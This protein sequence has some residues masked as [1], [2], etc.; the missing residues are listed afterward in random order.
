MNWY[1]VNGGQQA[2]PVDD[3]QLEGL[4]RA[5]QVRAETLV[6]HEGMANW[7]P[8]GQVRPAPQT[9]VGAPPIPAAATVPPATG[10]GEVVCAE[11]GRIFPVD[12]TIQYGT[13]RVCAGCKPVF[14]QKLTEGATVE[15]VLGAFRYG[16]FWIRVAA[17]LLDGLIMGVIIGIP[18]GIWLFA[19]GAL[20]DPRSFSDPGNA[21]SFRLV[22]QLAFNCFGVLVQVAYEGFFVAKFAAT[23][24]KMACGLKVVMADGSRVSAGRAVGR[25]F[26]QILSR[27]ICG[28]GYLIVAFDAEKRA[29]HDHICNTRVVYK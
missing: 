11:C 4:V 28:I 13:A 10:P 15:P 23:P 20:N 16:G 19:S 18:L 2:G 8:Y 6:W 27:I 24:G 5:G 25:A 1:Y 7:Q 21:Q 3:A 12:Q 14:M 17:K 9:P 29:L 22:M 26:A